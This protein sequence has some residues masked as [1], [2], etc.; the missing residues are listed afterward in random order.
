MFA[1]FVFALGIVIKQELSKIA[2]FHILS[3]ISL[4]MRD[5]LSTYISTPFCRDVIKKIH[6][7]GKNLTGK[8][9]NIGLNDYYYYPAVNK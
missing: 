3:S 5:C 2:Y 8:W 4:F 6:S 1:C 9:T 7:S